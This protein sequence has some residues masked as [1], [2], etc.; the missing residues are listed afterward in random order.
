MPGPHFP[1]NVD[2]PTGHCAPKGATGLCRESSAY[3]SVSPLLIFLFGSAFSSNRSWASKLPGD[4]R[5]EER[6]V[7]DGGSAPLDTMRPEGNSGPHSDRKRRL[8]NWSRSLLRLSP[9]ESR[10]RGS[11]R[12]L[13]V[14]CHP[15]GPTRANPTQLSENEN[16]LVIDLFAGLGGLTLALEKA[17]VHY[18]HLGIV[19]KDPECRR[20][21][22]RTY[23]GAAFYSKV[24]NFG[25]KEIKEL[26]KKVPEA[27]GIVVGG[28]SPCQGL[29]R[30]SSR[31]QHLADERSQLFYE[32]SRIFREVEEVAAEK[33]LWVLKLLENV[34]AD[35]A[36]IKE[37]SR[38]LKMKPV[39][40]DA[41]YLSRARRPRLFWLSVEPGPEDDVGV[42]LHRDYTQLVYKAKEEPLELFLQ[43]NCEWEAGLRSEKARFPTFTRSIPRARPPPDPAGLSETGPAGVARW[44]ADQFRYP[45][46]TYKDEYMV[47]TP[48]CALRPLVAEERRSSWDTNQATRQNCS[49]NR[50][51]VRLKGEPQRICSVQHWGIR[52][53]PTAWPASWIMPWRPW[54]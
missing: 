40:V 30:L 33:K 16:V 27:S 41:Q 37:M 22:R 18:K 1:G 8:R 31:R 35:S 15:E 20:L 49:R 47:L 25:K 23:P 51:R 50:P 26:L 36:D 53:T 28:G 17:G 46:Y 38:E 52:S 4:G 12:N 44:E 45:P 5:T 2:P 29:S 14:Q 19:E 3:P 24:E 48:E 34:I 43:P 21:L 42:I 39:M 13:G 32:A 54:G 9:H 7:H 10:R 6:D 11:E